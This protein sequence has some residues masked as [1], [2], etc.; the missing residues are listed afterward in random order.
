MVKTRPPPNKDMPG[1]SL[2]MTRAL[3]E[4]SSMGEK[5]QLRCIQR[6]G[7]RCGEVRKAARWAARKEAAWQARLIKETEVKA[8]P[9][10]QKEAPPA[11][12]SHVREAR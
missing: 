6:R 1:H 5:A 11:E 10:S 8:R 4:E 9:T 12:A 7:G 2:M 3:N